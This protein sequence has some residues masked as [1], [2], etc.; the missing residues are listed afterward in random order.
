M[1]AYFAQPVEM[2]EEN[3]VTKLLRRTQKKGSDFA[4]LLLKTN[5]LTNPQSQSRRFFKAPAIESKPAPRRINV[6]GSGT[7]A[8]PAGIN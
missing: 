7:G 6:P 4:T 5:F 3:N 1:I 2:I 8:P